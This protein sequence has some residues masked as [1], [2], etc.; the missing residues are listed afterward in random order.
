[1][2]DG[3]VAADPLGVTQPEFPPNS[4]RTL[5][6]QCVAKRKLG[7]NGTH[8]P[9]I[10]AI[11]ALLAHSVYVAREPYEMSS[12]RLPSGSRKYTLVPSPWAPSRVIGPVSTATPCRLR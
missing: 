3:N 2:P 11:H 10:D 4:F 1:M 12:S 9:A 7:P 5:T 6:E 8:E